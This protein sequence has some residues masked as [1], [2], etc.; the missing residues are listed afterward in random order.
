MFSLYPFWSSFMFNRPSL[1]KPWH[2]EQCSNNFKFSSD[3]RKHTR[4]HMRGNPFVCET[5]NKSFS[6]PNVLL[7]HQK[8]HM[9][10]VCKHC[11]KTI[12]W[13]NFRIHLCTHISYKPFSCSICSKSLKRSV[14]LKRHKETHRLEVSLQCVRCS[15]IVCP[16]KL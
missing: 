6:M 3:L 4:I 14:D 15:N 5:C 13:M 12:G 2:C 8:I 10:R 16:E 11:L 9:S 1:E 7:T